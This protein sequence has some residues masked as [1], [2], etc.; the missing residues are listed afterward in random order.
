MFL[1]A[2]W[3]LVVSI[4]DD[5]DEEIV[6]RDIEIFVRS[7]T[8]VV[9]DQPTQSFLEL[10]FIL[11]VHCYAHSQGRVLVSYTAAS[12]NFSQKTSLF[13]MAYFTI[14]SESGSSDF[15]IEFG[16]CQSHCFIRRL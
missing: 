8:I 7:E 11:V 10:T 14:W 15:A 2:I 12:S 5:E 9:M 6:L 4:T 1:E 13:N 16:L 3:K